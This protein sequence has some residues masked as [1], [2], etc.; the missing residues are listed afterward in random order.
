MYVCQIKLYVSFS[1]TSR[2]CGVFF[3][4]SIWLKYF[5]TYNFDESLPPT[6]SLGPYR[7]VVRGILRF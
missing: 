6:I 2:D 7:W 5:L 4:I 3:L 1:V